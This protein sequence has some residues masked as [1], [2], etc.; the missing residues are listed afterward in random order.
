MSILFLNRILIGSHFLI[1]IFMLFQMS[2]NYLFSILYLELLISKSLTYHA[3]IAI[4]DSTVL[5]KMRLDFN[6]YFTEPLWIEYFFLISV[7]LFSIYYFTFASN[8]LYNICY[9]MKLLFF[10]CHF[11][12]C[13]WIFYE[14]SRFFTY[15][16]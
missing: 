10:N 2:F 9:I 7:L 12:I 15:L 14:V 16:L 6:K 3:M 8:M 1:I 13:I 5:L 11:W 4:Y